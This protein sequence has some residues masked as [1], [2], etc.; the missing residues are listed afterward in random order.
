MNPFFFGTS[1]KQLFGVH[2]PPLIQATRSTAVLLCYPFGD[3]YMRTHKAMRQLAIQLA[4][5]G[6]HVL[7]FDYFGT[8]DSAGNGEDAT[9]EQWIEDIGVAADELKDTSGHAKISMVGLRLGGTLAVKAAA[10]RA[11]V[12]HLLLWDPIVDGAA[13]FKELMLTPLQPGAAPVL[14]APGATASAAGFPATP[15]LRG[16]L[17]T[18]DLRAPNAVSPGRVTQ[19]VSHERDEFTGLRERLQGRP[20]FIYQHAP[21]PAPWIEPEKSAGAMVLPHAII[22]AIV[23]NLAGSGE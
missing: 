15:A 6:F 10:V 22:Q 20:D 4:K 2:H 9:M 1:A 7:R 12:D 11:D 14:P 19:I 3:E 5:A 13:Y 8:G 21:S 18:L 16:E 23:S 17:A